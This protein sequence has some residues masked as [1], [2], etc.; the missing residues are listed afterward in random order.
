MHLISEEKALRSRKEDAFTQRLFFFRRRHYWE[1]GPGEED[2][3]NFWE[4]GA[5]AR[6]EDAF[7]LRQFLKRRRFQEG[8]LGEEDAFNF[9]EEG[10]PGKEERHFHSKAVFKRGWSQRGIRCCMNADQLRRKRYREGGSGEE[11]AFTLRQ[12]LWEKALSGCSVE[13][14]FKETVKKSKLELI[15]CDATVN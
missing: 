15:L 10:A 6:K 11:D 14:A 2:A 5:L 3:F 4:E 7:T 9:W 8:G 1:G 12:N 13:G